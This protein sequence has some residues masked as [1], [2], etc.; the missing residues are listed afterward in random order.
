MLMLVLLLML[1]LLLCFYNDMLIQR[2]LIFFQCR[3]FKF[4]STRFG[5][6]P[7][8]SF[9]T[10]SSDIA[11]IKFP[12]VDSQP[13]FSIT[14]LTSSNGKGYAVASSASRIRYMMMMILLCSCL[15]FRSIRRYIMLTFRSYCLYPTWLHSAMIYFKSYAI[16]DNN[17]YNTS[18]ILLH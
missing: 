15:Q 9:T 16:A 8:I 14:S 4:K 7:S 3:S 11:P 12:F 5:L 17:I 1:M 2:T 10:T 6:S 18:I 13:D